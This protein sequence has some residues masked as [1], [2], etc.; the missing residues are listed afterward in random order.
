MK[1]ESKQKAAATR[2][3]NSEQ[4]LAALPTARELRTM[5][6]LLSVRQVATIMCICPTTVRRYSASGK[7]PHVRIG[8]RLRFYPA[9]VAD[10]L[11]G[12]FSDI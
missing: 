1:H 10:F 4:K 11:E 2:K 8:N 7:L 5:R 9:V 12:R 6:S 3:H